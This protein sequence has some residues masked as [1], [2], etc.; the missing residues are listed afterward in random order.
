MRT[1]TRRRGREEKSGLREFVSHGSGS[2]FVIR[3]EERRRHDTLFSSDRRYQIC[4]TASAHNGVL[5]QHDWSLR[6]VTRS[7]LAEHDL[8]TTTEP[9]R[10]G[11]SVLDPVIEAT[12][13][14]YDLCP[15]Q[16]IL[17]TDSR[18]DFPRSGRLARHS[19][20]HISPL[21]HFR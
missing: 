8:R 11:G 17:L 14:I 16:H 15:V 12:S 10:T 13:Q 19:A 3:A 7:D 4:G 18:V 21:L 20:P 2:D 6:C 9:L 5:V 1:K